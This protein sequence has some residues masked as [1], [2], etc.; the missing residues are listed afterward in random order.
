[1]LIDSNA[2]LNVIDYFGND[3]LLKS[4]SGHKDSYETCSLFLIKAGCSINQEIKQ[5]NTPLDIAT[6]Y[7]R[8][9]I[10]NS[11]NSKCKPLYKEYYSI[12]VCC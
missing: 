3:A 4:L 6:T 8:I 7:N 2:K 10:I 5:G 9:N 12:V 1:M 11:K